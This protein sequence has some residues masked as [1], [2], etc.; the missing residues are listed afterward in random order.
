MKAKLELRPATPESDDRNENLACWLVRVRAARS[1]GLRLLREGRE[2]LAGV[3]RERV[4]RDGVAAQGEELLVE[5]CGRRPRRAPAAR[6]RASRA[7]AAGSGWSACRRRRRPP[8]RRARFMQASSSAMASGKCS[9]LARR[10]V[11]SRKRASQVS[12]RLMLSRN[13]SMASGVALAVD[14]DLGRD[15]PR[16]GRHVRLEHVLQRRRRSSRPPPAGRPRPAPAPRGG[17]RSRC[18][19]S[20]AALRA[21]SDGARLLAERQVALGRADVVAGQPAGVS[22]LLVVPRRPPAAS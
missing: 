16:V 7:R 12:R 8:P 4:G 18:R 20:P 17:G 13:S 6:A 9:G 22:R 1:G 19:L 11:P 15:E 2:P 14:R 3:D 21:A 10:A 5:C